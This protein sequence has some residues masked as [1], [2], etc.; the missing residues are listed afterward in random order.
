[1]ATPSWRYC[2]AIRPTDCR[3]FPAS[4]RRPRPRCWRS[5]AHWQQS[6]PPPTIR[7]RHWPKAFGPSCGR[8]PTTSRSPD[9]S[10]G[11]PPMRR[12]R[13]RRP[14]MRCRWWRPT[15]RGSL[16]SRPNW[17][18]GHRSRG[19]RRRSTRCREPALLRPTHL[20]G[21]LVVLEG[22]RHRTLGAVDADVAVE[23]GALFDGRVLT[24]VALDVF[25]VL[26]AVAVGAVAQDLLH[27][28][29]GFADVELGGYE[30]PRRPEAQHQDHRDGD[31][32]DHTDHR[33][34]HRLRALRP[35]RRL[36]VG[37]PVLAVLARLGVLAGLPVLT[38]LTVLSRLTVLAR[39]GLAVLT[40][41]LRVSRGLAAVL[42]LLRVAPRIGL[43]RGA[44]RRGGAP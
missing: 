27:A 38:R 34:D 29:I 31:G 32:G 16:N 6:W 11:W 30:E 15:Q 24:V 22:R 21:A 8:P 10:C 12:S 37:T 28:G 26:R 17:A 40:R 1:M 42:V 41:L 25:D 2:A 19:C 18:A 7:N 9:R 5:T 35:G 14:P 4:A 23:A 43:G 33:A 39:L 3:A 44:V 36:A 13:S 20:V